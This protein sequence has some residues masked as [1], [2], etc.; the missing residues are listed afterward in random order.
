MASSRLVTARASVRAMMRKS[1]SVRCSDGGADLLRELLG[2]HHLLA[3]DV[4]ALLGRDLVLHVQP[5]HARLLVLAH[6][7]HRVQRVAV[8]GVG[9]GDHRQRHRARQVRGVIRHLG[10]GGEAEVGLAQ[11]RGG[12]ARAR[13]VHR[14]EARRLDEARGEA[15]VS[16]GRH[17]EAGRGEKLAETSGRAHRS[18]FRGSVEADGIVP[19]SRGTVNMVR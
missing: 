5:R 6:R 13:H 4:P 14:G 15:V 18:S 8:A 17:D 10:E 9:V 3:G 1:G 12:G 16:A 11:V 2:R 19:Q 7:A